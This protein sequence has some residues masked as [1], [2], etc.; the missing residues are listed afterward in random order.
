MHK[1]NTH[2]KIQ[3]VHEKFQNIN[4]PPTTIKCR[5]NIVRLTSIFDKIE[6]KKMQ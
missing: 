1:I 2:Q 4:T 6:V 5:F 3:H